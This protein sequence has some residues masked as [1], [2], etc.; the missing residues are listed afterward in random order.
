LKGKLFGIYKREMLSKARYEN[1]YDIYYD[2]PETHVFTKETSNAGLVYY[3][4]YADN[5]TWSGQLRLRGLDTGRQYRVVDYVADST[6]G[7]VTGDKPL[8]KVSFEDYLLI[9]CI[10]Q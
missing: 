7:T 6:L 1:Q 8:I 2:K 4:M 3:S 10:P 5:S 9:K